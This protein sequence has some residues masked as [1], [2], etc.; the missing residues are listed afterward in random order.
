[1][2]IHCVEPVLGQKNNDAESVTNRHL[3]NFHFIPINIF[4]NPK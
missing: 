2:T 1:M 3:K 4:K